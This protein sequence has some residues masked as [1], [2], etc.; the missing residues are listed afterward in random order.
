MDVKTSYTFYGRIKMTIH[1]IL[2]LVV[3][4]LGVAT[5]YVSSTVPRAVYINPVMD[6]TVPVDPVTPV[7]DPILPTW[8]AEAVENE[9]YCLAQNMYF[10]GRGEGKDGWM[11]VA[12]VTINRVR[13]SRYPNT[14]CDVVW[15]SKQFSWTH[16]GLSDNPKNDKQ[17]REIVTIA[18]MLTAEGTLGNAHDST[19]GSTH[20]HAT[21]IAPYWSDSFT[22]TATI[23]N[24]KFYREPNSPVDSYAFNT[25]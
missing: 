15:Q 14:V 17:W 6:E 22:H 5:G 12:H 10:E 13:S 4:M 9:A 16:D 19:K 2:L 25:L 18:G 7:I 3:F 11:A 20:F 23:G 1:A 24:H 21:R 8:T